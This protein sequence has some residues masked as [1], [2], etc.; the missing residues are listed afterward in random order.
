LPQLKP[1]GYKAINLGSDTLVVLM[2]AIRLTEELVGRAA[3]P[4]FVDRHPADVTA[5]WADISKAKNLL[6]W[7][8]QIFRRQGME[9]SGRFA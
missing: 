4:H 5:L 6:G 3:N 1:L 2:E 7:W 9:Q 8:L